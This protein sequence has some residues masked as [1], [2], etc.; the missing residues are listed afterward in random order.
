MKHKALTFTPLNTMKNLVIMISI[1]LGSTLVFALSALL[2][3]LAYAPQFGASPNEAARSN[4]AEFEFFDGTKFFNAVPTEMDMQ[5]SEI[6]KMMYE[7]WFVKGNKVPPALLP[8][9]NFTT[10]DLA[11]HNDSN[12]YYR[13]FGHSAIYMEIDGK[14]LLLDPMLGPAAAPHPLLGPNRF[15]KDLPI[16]PEDLPEIDAV[17]FSHDHYDHLDHPTIVK[18]KDKV[19]HFYVPLGLGSHLEK[20]GVVKEKITELKWWDEM[21]F[22]GIRLACT[23]A[24]HF[25]GRSMTDRNK[26]LWASWVIQ[27]KHHKVF[28]SGDGGY[29][30]GFKDIGDKYGP[31]DLSFMECGAYNV[32]WHAI[33]MYPEESAQAGVDLQSR[34]MM[35]IHWGGFNLSLHNWD[36]SPKR[37]GVKAKELGLTLVTPIIGEEVIIPAYVPNEQWWD[38]VH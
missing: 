26:T 4:Y 3:F 37:V 32:R 11:L 22:D 5:L 17:I 20:W 36:D 28:F 10:A 23:P 16:R 15:N 2:V 34:R 35:P 7:F 12:L 14:R 24:R 27:G 38:G 9:K 25:S 6:P 31:F 13:W 8:Q 21:D 19:G 30:H 29:W 1:L 33:H 18:I